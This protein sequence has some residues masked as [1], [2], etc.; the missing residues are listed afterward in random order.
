MHHQAPV[1]PQNYDQAPVVP[2]NYDQDPY[3]NGQNHASTSKSKKSSKRASAPVPSKSTKKMAP[4]N[5]NA[6]PMVATNTLDFPQSQYGGYPMS[7]QRTTSGPYPSDRRRANSTAHSAIDHSVFDPHF[8]PMHLFVSF[9]GYN[10]LR[11]ENV[12]VTAMHDLRRLI[13]PKWPEGLVEPD[14]LDQV[15]HISVAKFKGQPWDM[16][17][18]H[19]ITAIKLLEEFITLFCRKGYRYQTSYNTAQQV[20]RLV[21]RFEES[22]DRSH[23]FLACY[24]SNGRRLTIVNAPSSVDL[25]LVAKL[26]DMMPRKLLVDVATGVEPNVVR[27]IELKRGASP[28]V[29]IASSFFFAKVLKIL[30]DLDYELDFSLALQRRQSLGMRGTQEVLVFRSFV[31]SQ[32]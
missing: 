25:A 17:G 31:R 5:V 19:F 24:S 1:V 26:N 3:M 30:H 9:I 23:F 4:I 8:T 16:G 11:L 6:T 20:P 15:Q 29:E 27:N 7:R 32:F 21:F 22:D 14:T 13:W 10:E 12:S 2:Q 28:A 18:P